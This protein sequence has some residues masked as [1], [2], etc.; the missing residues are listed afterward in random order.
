VSDDRNPNPVCPIGRA[1]FSLDCKQHDCMYNLGGR[2]EYLSGATASSIENREERRN[3]VCELYRISESD[4]QLS[5]EKITLAALVNAYFEYLFQKPILDCKQ[6][7]LV[8]FR[9]TESRY[10]AWRK[11]KKTP[12]FERVLNILDE[13]VSKL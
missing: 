3:A 9:L 8:E 2:C 10:Y 4:L 12:S 5:L 11:K 6:K 7:D 1:Q 13:I